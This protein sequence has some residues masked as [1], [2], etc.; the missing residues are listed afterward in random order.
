MQTEE[1]YHHWRVFAGGAAGVCIRF[2]RAALTKAVTK[3]DGIRMAEVAHHTLNEIRSHKLEARR[4]PFL[5]RS[6]FQDEQE[7]RMIYESSKENL[8]CLDIPIP[9]SCITR[10]TLSPW[11]PRVL[12]ENIKATLRG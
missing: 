4:L 3:H 8:D 5:K 12:V 9:L 6:A 10:I 1:R 2:N 11:L 7:F